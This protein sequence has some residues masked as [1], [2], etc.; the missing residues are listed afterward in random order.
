MICG[1]RK[2]NI[3]HTDSEEDRGE[4]NR[5]NGHSVE[6]KAKDAAHKTITRPVVGGGGDDNDGERGAPVCVFR[7]RPKDSNYKSEIDFYFFFLF[8]R[9]K[10]SVKFKFHPVYTRM[11]NVRGGRLWCRSCRGSAL[12]MATACVNDM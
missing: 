6:R 1:R 2:L 7:S 10:P 3:K 9:T 11:Y 5:P 4:F 8:Y 12:D